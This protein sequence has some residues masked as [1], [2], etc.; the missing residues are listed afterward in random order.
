MKKLLGICGFIG[1]FFLSAC[2]E[3]KVSLEGLDN[4]Y[5][6]LQVGNYWKMDKTDSRTVIETKV[7]DQKNYYAI[8]TSYDTSY[9]RNENDKIVEYYKGKTSV[10]FD[11]TAEVNATWKYRDYTVTLTSKTETITIGGQKIKN[12]YRFYFDIPA[13]ADEEHA[14]WLAPGIGFI[15]YECL[16]MCVGGKDK[17]KEMKIDGKVYVL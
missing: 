11:L 17:L 6:P 13:L 16:G 3:N 1:A 14:I 15:Q 5:L 9:V 10:R 8:T 7:F 12:C 4:A 2:K